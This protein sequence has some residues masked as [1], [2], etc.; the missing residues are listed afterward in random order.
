MTIIELFVLVH[1]FVY[2]LMFSF[3]C[4]RLKAEKFGTLM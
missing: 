4:I 2:V 1:L 3:L